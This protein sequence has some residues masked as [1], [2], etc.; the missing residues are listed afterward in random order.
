M[1]PIG[2]AFRRWQLREVYFTMARQMGKTNGGI[3]NPI[4]QRLDDD[5][6]PILYI[7]PTRDNIDD[8]I[9]PKVQFMLE[10]TP[11]LWNKTLKGQKN[12]KHAKMV[13]GVSLRFAWAGSD[14]GLKADAAGLV[15]IDEI[16]GIEA[17]RP[18]AGEGT[19]KDMAAAITSSFPE[20]CVG[21]TSTPTHGAVESERHPVTGL[22][23]WSYSEQV[24]SAIWRYWQEGSRHEWAVPCPHCKVYFIP[25]SK[26]LRPI[27]QV[28]PD[29]AERN[30]HLACPNCGGEIRD[31]HRV[32]ANARGCMV[33]PGQLPAPYDHTW[34]RV[35]DD[36]IVGQGFL[37][38]LDGP[39]SVPVRVPWGDFVLDRSASKASF[40]VSGLCTFSARS[41]FGY[42]AEKLV[43]ALKSLLPQRI[44]GV[45]NTLFGECYLAKGDTPP[46]TEVKSLALRSD[47]VLGQV[48]APVTT[49]TAAVDLSDN[50]LQWAVRGWVPSDDPNHESY[51][52]QRGVFYGPTDQDDVW[53]LLKAR[54]LEATYEGLKISLMA[55]DSG[56]REQMVYEFCKLND[57][58]IPTK[59]RD[60]MDAWWKAAKPEVDTR[61]KVRR[62]GL[63][64]WHI[65]TDVVKSWVHSQV[66]HSARK[67]LVWHL[68][69]DIDDEYCKE[70][71]SESRLIDDRGVPYWRKHRPNHF[72]DIEGLLWFAANQIQI[73]AERP[74]PVGMLI[75]SRNHDAMVSWQADDPWLQGAG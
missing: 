10:S 41:S 71:T 53:K 67:E 18:V 69:S 75:K 28:T 35:N 61:G 73:K 65:N 49:L 29:E 24:I 45:F 21:C 37:L 59:G 47:Y 64:L 22:E 44:Q 42:I 20:G 13:N 63:K 16:D 58:A 17:D 62:Y 56:H 26:Y 25:R 1:I 15:F 34:G 46:W 7:G 2:R 55:I 51:L 3:Y 14:T 32:W 57:L 19:V 6:V 8:V 39:E 31:K 30:G 70:I 11:S 68:P 36:A 43:T 38:H 33:A 5:P 40:W 48:P 50:E 52:I 23:H 4:G 72:L 54:V 9:E 74:A 66:K 27:E 60:T 12:K